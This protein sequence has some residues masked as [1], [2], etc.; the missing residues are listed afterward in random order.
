MFSKA[1]LYGVLLSTFQNFC[2]IWILFSNTYT[3]FKNI[4]L[5]ALPPIL[6]HL[7]YPVVLVSCGFGNMDQVTLGG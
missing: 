6:T 2:I 1:V 5:S 3:H 4:Q 7:K